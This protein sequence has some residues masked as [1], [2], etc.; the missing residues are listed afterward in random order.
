MAMRKKGN[1]AAELE[2]VLQKF[3][4]VADAIGMLGI[5][6]QRDFLLR[7]KQFLAQKI[8]ANEALSEDDLMGIAAALLNVETSLADFGKNSEY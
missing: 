5:N 6:T 8:A 4:T 7:Q 1:A 2:N 3:S